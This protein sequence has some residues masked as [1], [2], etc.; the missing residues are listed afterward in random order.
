MPTKEFLRPLSI[1]QQHLRLQLYCFVTETPDLARRVCV[2]RRKW[3]FLSFYSL[4]ST[5]LRFR[6]ANKITTR[7]VVRIT[8]TASPE[9]REICIVSRVQRF[10]FER[11]WLR[12]IRS[13]SMK[14]G[15]SQWIVRLDR[16]KIEILHFSSASRG[17]ALAW[18]FR[19]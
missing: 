1:L 9:F 17:F 3:S 12:F 16:R 2:T 13:E 11:C 19:A 10:A 14:S 6:V 4:E 18:L 5:F 15:G 8:F 7:S